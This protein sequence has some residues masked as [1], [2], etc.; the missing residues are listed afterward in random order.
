MKG[1]WKFQKIVE[2]S[3]KVPESLRMTKEIFRNF[4][5]VLLLKN[6]KSSKKFKKRLQKVQR[7]TI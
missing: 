4:S 1:F 5:N 3:K 7:N 6:L 2:S